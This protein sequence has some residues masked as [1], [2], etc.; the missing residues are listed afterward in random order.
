MFFDEQYKEKQDENTITECTDL[1]N[2]GNNHFHLK[3][4]D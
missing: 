1:K 4:Y 3:Q 2:L